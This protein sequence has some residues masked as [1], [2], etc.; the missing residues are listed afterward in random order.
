MRHGGN[1]WDQGEPGQW[2]DFSANLRPEG[3]PE[4]VLE[5]M[6]Q[7]LTD[8]RYYPDRAMRAA[9]R[10]LAVYAG[11]PET[12]IL[13]T[14]GGAAAIDLVLSDGTGRVLLTPPTFG[15]YAERAAAH[16][17]QV[18]FGGTPVHGDTRVLCNPNN[19]TG[20]T[21]ERDAVLDIYRRAADCGAEL[22]VDEAF[23]DF[24]ETKSVRRDV[25]EGLTVTGSLTK[26]LCIPG[27]RLGY[28]CAA[29]ERIRRLER[30][31]LTWSLNT[32]ASAVAAA[33]PAHLEEIRED[34]QR[35]VQR[36]EKLIS[37]L[38]A[39]NIR[40]NPS[41]VNFLLCD[42]ALDTAPLVAFLRDKKIL[43]RTCDSFGLGRNVLRLAVKTEEENRT[44]L[45]AIA[46][47]KGRTSC[48]E[49]H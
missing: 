41:N 19:P 7:A 34:M 15:E 43:V 13:P 46:Q 45:A 21:L 47:W 42:F 38:E 37:G 1:V 31:A 2:L 10:G 40:V 14:A 6:R 26:T 17:R 16:G 3:T 5:T 32:L 35:N 23:I 30:R 48:V 18:V 20:E 22:M 24:C 29:P 9:R 8:T 36:R 25:T 27:V 33:L 49:S 11:V 4:W 12:C 28:I 39:L 44:L